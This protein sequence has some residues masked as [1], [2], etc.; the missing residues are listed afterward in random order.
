MQDVA[1]VLTQQDR[2]WVLAELGTISADLTAQVEVKLPL[3]ARPGAA[4]LSIIDQQENG[5]ELHLIIT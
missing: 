4:V 3:E 2:R 5:T 1:V